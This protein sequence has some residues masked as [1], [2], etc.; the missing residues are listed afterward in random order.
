MK[1]TEPTHAELQALL[2]AFGEAPPTPAN[3]ALRDQFAAEAAMIQSALTP[4]REHAEIPAAVL[5]RLRKHG[6]AAWE[7][8]FGTRAPFGVSQGGGG[9][10]RGTSKRSFMTSAWMALAAAVVVLGI[11]AKLLLPGSDASQPTIVWA[12]AAD[13][14]Q[15]YDVWILPDNNIEKEDAEVLFKAERVRSPVRFNQFAAKTSATELDTGKSHR[16]LVCLANAGRFAGEP[17]KFMPAAE[18]T[19][20]TP[21]APGMLRK[22]LADKR[23][24]EAQQLLSALPDSVREA[25]EVLELAKQVPAP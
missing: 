21:T 22:L 23:M 7:A 13:P 6:D 8:Q 16:L 24:K 20:P 9:T 1:P 10:T 15:Q 12:N 25:P 5:D 17:V 4:P 18:V 2:E 11:A 19:S 14:A 3:A